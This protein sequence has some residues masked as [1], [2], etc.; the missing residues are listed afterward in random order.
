[1]KIWNWIKNNIL[2]I[3]TIFLLAFIPLYPKIPLV[4]IQHTWVYIRFE[5]LA[6]VLAV[7]IWITLLVLK[8]VTLRTPLTIPI[9]V[10]WVIG[11]ITTLHG[12]LLLFP[13]LSN[14]F[15]NVAFLSFMRR[16]E[17]L[18]LFF[19][20]YAGIKNKKSIYYVAI[21]L[22]VTL[23]LVIFYGFGQKYLGFPAFLTMNEEFA[24]G[25]PIRLSDL[26]RVPST[27]AGQYDLAAYLVLIIPVIVSLAFGFKNIITK[28]I[29]FITASLGFALLFMTVSRIS[30]FALLFSLLLLLILMRKKLIIISLLVLTCLLLIFSPSLLQRFKSTVAE[31]NVLVDARTGGAIGEV[32]EVPA[33]Y[34]KDKIVKKIP[35][36]GDSE[37]T[38][39]AILPFELIP[40]VVP[41]VVEA[42]NSSTGESLPQGTSYENLP[43]S[44]VVKKIDGYF[45]QKLVT[46]AGVEFED[47]TIYYGDYLI[48]RAKAYDLSFT[49]R[50]QGEWPNTFEAFKRNIFIG[51]G[52]GSVSL[53]V[54][55]NYLRILGESGLFGFFA[56][57]S[58]FIIAMIYV[59]KFLSKVDS[60]VARSFIV[61]FVAG[62]LGLAINASLIDVFEASK[63]A[64]T[65][66]LLMGVVIGVLCLY[67]KEE[68]NFLGEFKKVVT[69][70]VAVVIYILAA[71]AA[72]FYPMY[73]NYF[74]GDDF[75]WLRWAQNCCSNTLNYFT[76]ANGFFYRPGTKLYF[77]LMYSGFWLNQTMYHLVSIFLHFTACVL[78]F[79]IL[80]KILKDYLLSIVCVALFIILSVHHEDIFWISS[81]GFLFNAVFALT[82]LL[83]YIFYVEKKRVI[84]LIVSL[85]SIVLCLLFHEVGVV[86]PLLIILYDFLFREK[87]KFSR[88]FKKGTYLVLLSPIL[89][90]LGLRF[91]AQSHWAGGDY[92]YNLIKLP[93]NIVGNIIGYI[94]LDFIGPQALPF[95][96]K[97]RDFSKDHLLIFVPV[98]LLAILAVIMLY[99]IF[100][101]KAGEESR[102]IVIFGFWFFFIALLPFLG[103]GNIASRYS[104]LSS[105]GFVIILGLV[106][107][108]LYIYLVNIG[109]KYIGAFVIGIITIIFFMLQLFALQNIHSEWTA[110]GNEAQNFLISVE[111]HAGN[112]WINEKLKFYFVGMPI[113]NGEA[114]VWPVGLKDAL[115]FAFKNPNLEVITSQDLNSAFNS[116]AGLP[117]A[118]VFIFGQN[119]NVTEVVRGKNGQIYPLN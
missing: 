3:F 111:E 27:F 67:K 100:V 1:M 61:G 98:F 112:T 47:V 38:G 83:F 10:F 78:L 9:L 51:S 108:K 118:H 23:L 79:F 28:I 24:K 45:S 110:A 104:Y 92:S 53:A 54:D 106:L 86:V 82:S 117:N 48:K 32:K 40:P 5:D 56:F 115:W 76:Q 63:I 26:S 43:L 30:F 96:E 66:W 89:P 107:K 68:I 64:F 19:V 101:A 87:S 6:V 72:I 85:V 7:F 49:T 97:L 33:A 11:G 41:L 34:F 80:R 65:Y 105:I 20:A 17:Y 57:A 8:K 71:V 74:V 13:T 62:S 77:S 37:A 90:Y 44:P 29:L 91:L 81:T 60:P 70:P 59:R 55:N 50:F 119:G 95:Y 69:S 73:V 52:Y 36:A 18:S 102:K 103:L 15:S 75:T 84:Y 116:S 113:K 2:F 4:D 16:I 35:S 58:I 93:Y 99:K 22:V 94:S 114:W 12:V 21:T 109:D 88:L 46:K 31:V 25:V 14:L 39:S 42:N